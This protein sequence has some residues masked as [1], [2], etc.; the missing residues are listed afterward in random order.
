M[1]T[2]EYILDLHGYTVDETRKVLDAIFFKNNYSYIRIIFGKGIHS[3]NGP[4]LG[5]FVKRYLAKKSVRFNQAKIQNGGEG[6]L[7]V[8]MNH[9]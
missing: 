4:V 2:P 3:K 5:Q 9:K 1:Q 8:F 7:E 6:A